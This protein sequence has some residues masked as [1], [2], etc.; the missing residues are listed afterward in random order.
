MSKADLLLEAIGDIDAE[1]IPNLESKEK[2]GNKRKWFIVIST[3][4]VAALAVIV[5]ILFFMPLGDKTVKYDS[6]ALSTELPNEHIEAC[7][8]INV[9]NPP[10]LIGFS[11]YVFVAKVEEELRTEYHNLIRREFGRV[12]GTPY[13]FY[14]ITVVDNIK[15]NLKKNVPIEMKK[16]GGVNYDQSSISTFE[17]DVMLEPGK[18]YI[19]IANGQSDGS[20]KQ[21]EVN[22]AI[23]LTVS[24]ED[25]ISEC[26]EYVA[27][28]EYAANE[29]YYE[30]ER[31]HSIYE[32]ES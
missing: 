2:S 30:R 14:S 20:L 25:E 29:I 10:T 5:Y 23:K 21:S 28:K 22:S 8:A 7:F 19:F 13:T 1:L 4:T 31:S 17:G 3:A 24:S 16:Q 12:T 15:G 11:D 9:Y 18:Y 26:K 32:E 6:F 27:Y